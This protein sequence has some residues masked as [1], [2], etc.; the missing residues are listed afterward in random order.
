M[1]RT[2]GGDSE[3]HVLNDSSGGGQLSGL[4]VIL[5][6]VRDSRGRCRIIDETELEAL[7]ADEHRHGLNGDRVNAVREIIQESRFE[8]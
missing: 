6:T 4:V 3:R 2:Q 7:V 8:H 1:L 5:D